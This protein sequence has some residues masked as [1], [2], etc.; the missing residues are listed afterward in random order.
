M[1][2]LWFYNWSSV[3][4]VTETFPRADFVTGQKEGL[5]EIVTS[6]TT[7]YKP[8]YDLLIG[9]RPPLLKVKLY[10][11]LRTSERS[12]EVVIT[13]P[14]AVMSGWKS[15]PHCHLWSPS[16]VVSTLP[17]RTHGRGAPR[18]SFRPPEVP[19]PGLSREVST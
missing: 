10:R 4:C 1:S 9:R 2:L 19:V 12:W 8:T 17:S 7:H 16:S 13:I 15:Y 6:T 5:V 14:G 3:R 18:W 11:P